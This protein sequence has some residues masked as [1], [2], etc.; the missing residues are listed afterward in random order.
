M[1]SSTATTLPSRGA[2]AAM[3]TPMGMVNIARSR[4]RGGEA[5]QAA[6]VGGNSCALGRIVT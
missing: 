1:R 6:K 2:S 4:L 3:R 5:T